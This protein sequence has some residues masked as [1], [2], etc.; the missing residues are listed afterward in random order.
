M[1][2]IILPIPLCVVCCYQ[3]YH[4]A[5][6][7][8]LVFPLF[9]WKDTGFVIQ[10]SSINHHFVLSVT[11]GI[12]IQIGAAVNTACTPHLAFPLF[13]VQI[14]HRLVKVN[15]TDTHTAMHPLCIRSFHTQTPLSPSCSE[16][17]CLLGT[18]LGTLSKVT[19]LLPRKMIPSD[20]PFGHS[21]PL[22]THNSPLGGLEGK[23]E[24]L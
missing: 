16:P 12:Q 23:K 15:K 21:E 14:G 20:I 19:A 7:Y 17:D 10:D 8:P 4:Y 22:S 24:K 5:M 13:F 11:S 18:S 3:S 6:Y 2:C 1:C 9:F